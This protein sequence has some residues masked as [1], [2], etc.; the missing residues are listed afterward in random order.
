MTLATGRTLTEWIVGM[1]GFADKHERL[2]KW[3]ILGF[4]AIVFAIV[5]FFLHDWSL[6]AV[7]TNL[8]GGLF[9]SLVIAGVAIVSALPG[10]IILALGRRSQMPV[11]RISA[12]AFIELLRSVPLITVLFMAVTMMPLFLP[13]DFQLN[14]LI[15]VIIGVCLFAAAY[16]AEVVRGGLQAVPNGQYEAAKAMGPHLLEEHESDHPAPGPEAH[17][18]QHRW[19]LHRPAEGYDAGIHH[20][21]VRHAGDAEGY[22]SETPSG[23]V[24]T[25]SRWSLVQ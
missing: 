6:V 4:T 10:G 18:S 21:P 23:S 3:P 22:R 24:C 9:L 14:K 2:H 8:W 11:V 12:I 13:P 1:T 5:Y 17:D 19:Q 7:D 25:R 16:M 15:Q 20:R